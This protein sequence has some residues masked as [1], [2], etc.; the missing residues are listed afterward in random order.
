VILL[1]A[2]PG[3]PSFTRIDTEQIVFS[4]MI[5]SGV[6]IML[7]VEWLEEVGFFCEETMQLDSRADN[8]SCERRAKF[9]A[10]ENVAE[11]LELLHERG[12]KL[13]GRKIHERGEKLRGRKKIF[14]RLVLR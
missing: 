8:G 10:E 4:T 2:L 3:F 13:R 12:G 14:S 6:L 9:G 1:F 5:Y 7:V 11:L